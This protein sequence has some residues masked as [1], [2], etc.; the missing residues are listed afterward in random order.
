MK[1]HITI[2]QLNELSEKGKEKEQIY[3]ENWYKT[4]YKGDQVNRWSQHMFW[5]IG[6]MIE[7]LEHN[8]LDQIEHVVHWTGNICEWRVNKKE[9]KEEICDAL[10]EA[11]KEVLNETGT[12][13]S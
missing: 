4:V 7:F 5:N 13:K 11:V 8:H 2:E 6:Q 12:E 3:R 1:Q 10:W 9:K